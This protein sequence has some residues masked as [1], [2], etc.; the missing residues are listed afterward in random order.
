MALVVILAERIWVD[1]FFRRLVEDDRVEPFAERHA[2]AARRFSGGLAGFRPD[3]FDTPRNA[4]FHALTRIR[5]G[6]KEPRMTLVEPARVN[7]W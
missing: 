7:S 6:G 2:G 3:A 5:G 1:A 4:K